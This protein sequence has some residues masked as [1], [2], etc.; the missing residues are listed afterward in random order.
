[1]EENQIYASVNEGK[2]IV[3]FYLLYLFMKDIN[4]L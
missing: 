2:T 1:M 3:P 4:F